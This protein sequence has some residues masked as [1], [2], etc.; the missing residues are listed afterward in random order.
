MLITTNDVF[1]D[2]LPLCSKNIDKKKKKERKRER[3]IIL[4]YIYPQFFG[5][6]LLIFGFIY[7]FAFVYSLFY[8]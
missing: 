2:I 6:I 1:R 5:A 3:N 8:Y 4:I 7:Y